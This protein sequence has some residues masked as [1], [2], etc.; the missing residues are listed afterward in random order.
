M[1]KIVS[2]ILSF[3]LCMT[4]VP[5]TQAASK[6]KLTKEMQALVDQG[7]ITPGAGGLFKPNEKVNRGDFA[8][9]ISRAL[10]L[11]KGNSTFKDVPK[12]T[13]WA[14][15]INAAA[16]AGIVKGITSTKFAPEVSITREQMSVMITRALDYKKVKAKQGKLTFLD[17]HKIVQKEAVMRMVGHKIILGTKSGNGYVF[18]PKQS[19]TRDHAAKF[20]YRMQE[21][22]KNSGEK[23][24]PP[25]SQESFVIG[26]VD[27]QGTFTP[28]SKSYKTLEEAEQA[29][30]NAENQV[31]AKDGNIIKMNKGIVVAKA[32]P[33]G[34]TTMYKK[35]E[36]KVTKVYGPLAYGSEI[37]YVSSDETEIKIKI[38]GEDAFVKHSEAILLPEIAIKERSYY[39][40]DSSNKL[41]H[42]I[43][44]HINK[45]SVP[46]YEYGIGSSKMKVG[47]RYYSWDGQTF[48]DKDGKVVDTIYQYFNMLPFRT[49][50]NYSAA[51]LNQMI[52]KELKRVEATTNPLYKDATKK[53]KLLG[54]GQIL[55]DVEKEYKVN[56]FMVLAFAI[57]ESQFGMSTKA[58]KENNLFGIGVHDNNPGGSS[59]YPTVKENI[60]VLAENTLNL[61]YIPIHDKS[62]DYAHGSHFGNK[63]RGLNVRYASDPYWGQKIAGHML[64]M[65]KNLGGGKDYVNN[66]TPFNV[67]KVTSEVGYL[68]VRPQADR[69]KPALYTLPRNGFV[70]AVISSE[71]KPDYTWYKILSDNTTHLY[72]YVAGGEADDPYITQIP[73]QK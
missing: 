40:V 9:Y 64:R 67:Y 1:K 14:A 63:S 60:R 17:N 37:E 55:K 34:M 54:I 65:D 27:T 8:T 3:L 6:E 33:Q 22:V 23:P 48:T 21:A 39:Q 59:S 5:V 62:T 35:I 58:Q 51:E 73:F 28:G 47:E 24:E 72:G 52:E 69:T 11:P 46:V 66:K 71:V 36:N 43:Y 4:L 29:F 26:T 49:T 30:T 12:G 68:H 42:H 56:A 44:D 38:A 2:V 45:K 18:N 32:K 53:S 41:T 13:E 10:K 57:H 70:V 25:I 15:G 20:I 50:T 7:V 61:R 31:I 19:A 16:S